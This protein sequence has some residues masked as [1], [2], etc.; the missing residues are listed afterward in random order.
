MHAYM[1]FCS[2]DCRQQVSREIS[3]FSSILYSIDNKTTT[4]NEGKTHRSSSGSTNSYSTRF[5]FHGRFETLSLICT[6]NTQQ[7]FHDGSRS[8][9][10]QLDEVNLGR[11]GM[12]ASKWGIR[13]TSHKP[14]KNRPTCHKSCTT[15]TSRAPLTIH[16]RSINRTRAC[17]RKEW[18]QHETYFHHTFQTRKQA[19]I[20]FRRL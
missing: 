5:T 1:P 15:S 19:G 16:Q 20:S 4:L 14:I 17:T 9:A 7:I 13:V 3:T 8:A 11:H 10:Q 6:Q 2:M 12:H 18:L